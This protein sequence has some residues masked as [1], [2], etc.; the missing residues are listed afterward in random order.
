MGPGPV[1]RW[2]VDQ[3]S[4]P[5]LTANLAWDTNTGGNKPV[6]WQWANQGWTDKPIG[7]IVRIPK[8]LP[9]VQKAGS[10]AASTEDCRSKMPGWGD[11]RTVAVDRR[12]HTITQI[13]DLHFG[14][15]NS[16]IAD[17][18]LADLHAQPPSLL[19][20]SGDLTQRARPPQFRAA[21]AFL[22]KCPT[23]RLI[24]PGN[25]DVPAVNLF[26][27]LFTPMANYRLHAQEDL[28]PVYHDDFMTVVGINTAHGLTQKGGRIGQ[29]QL[30][31]TKEHFD[32]A[33]A[34]GDRLRIVVA[35]HPFLPSPNQVRRD[36]VR[37]AKR[38]LAAFEQMGVDMILSGHFHMTFCGDVR[39]RHTSV[40]RSILAVNCG[41]TTSTRVRHGEPNAYNRIE[42]GLHRIRISH[43]SWDG[44]QFAESSSAIYT[45][46]ANNAPWIGGETAASDD[47]A[48]QTEMASQSDQQG[49]PTSA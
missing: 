24:I 25:H 8:V 28:A 41:T 38:A 16:A 35:H 11:W 1:G 44:R 32:S 43:R 47:A 19:V 23:P 5:H 20:V 17:A 15:V 26:S 46:P 14:R 33:A 18:L 12:M 37:G 6:G 4:R 29:L 13:S 9:A 49:L 27:R 34:E 31:E 40:N 30:A 7:S 22:A 45:R 3:A 2:P 42:M 36:L 48:I 21:M 10:P 39:S